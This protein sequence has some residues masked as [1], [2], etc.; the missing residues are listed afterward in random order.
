MLDNEEEIV[1]GRMRPSGDYGRY[2]SDG[3]LYYMGRVDK[4]V[5]R[6]GHRIN[7]DTIQQVRICALTHAHM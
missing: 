5:K 1:V 6:L 2:G 4:Q 3:L 7:L